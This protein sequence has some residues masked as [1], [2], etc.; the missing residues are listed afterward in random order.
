MRR[1]AIGLLAHEDRVHR[2]THLDPRG[3]ID[4]VARHH[5]LAFR[6]A[7]VERNQCLASIDAD[8]HL[9]VVALLRDAIADGKRRAHCSFWVVLVRDGRAEERHD[10]VADELLY[11]ATE[12]LELGAKAAVVGREQRT[13]VLGIEPLGSRREADEIDE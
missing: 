13:H 6:R 7:R 9:Q 5:R 11:R 1:G 2:R 12:A 10:S 3:G 8:A 4:H